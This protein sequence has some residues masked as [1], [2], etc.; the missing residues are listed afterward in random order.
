MCFFCGTL[1]SR[2]FGTSVLSF[3]IHKNATLMTVGITLYRVV[4]IAKT[5]RVVWNQNILAGGV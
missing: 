3:M 5:V 1:H 2:V 4:W